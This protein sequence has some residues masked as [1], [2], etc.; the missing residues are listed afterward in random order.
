MDAWYSENL[1]CPRDQTPLSEKSGK[2]IC[3]EG[4]CYPIAEGIP[5][6]LVDDVEQTLWVAA[7]SLE[8]ALGGPNDDG[9]Y[10][11]TVG[12]SADERNGVLSRPANAK[13]PID[14]VVAY[15]VA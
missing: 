6:M 10:L 12:I 1:V 7:K 13:Q 15:L 2:V 5:V 14:P 3:C 9:L 4:H 11:A 8:E